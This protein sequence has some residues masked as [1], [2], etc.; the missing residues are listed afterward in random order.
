MEA[1]NDI[2]NLQGAMT[3]SPPTTPLP[4]TRTVWID[5]Q[6][7][8]AREAYNIINP[9]Q[10]S[11]DPL[12]IYALFDNA[13]RATNNTLARSMNLNIALRQAAYELQK[14][15]LKQGR[16]NDMKRALM[17]MDL[18]EK[19]RYRRSLSNSEPR[20]RGQHTISV[21]SSLPDHPYGAP[22]RAMSYGRPVSV[23]CAK[24]AKEFRPVAIL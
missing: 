19:A 20:N 6:L 1:I 11:I 3:F 14:Q 23:A 21:G 7:E 2:S 16:E 24:G 15:K 9:P 17:R 22:V 18:A 12:Y 4:A 10:S 8:R 13:K 5:F